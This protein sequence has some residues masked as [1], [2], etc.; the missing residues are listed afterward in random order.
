MSILTTLAQVQNEM[1]RGVFDFTK[2]GNCIGCG[3]CCSNYL[4]ISS[5]EI[6]DIKRYIQKYHIEEHVRV[7]PTTN[8]T[9]DMTCPFL[10]E[11]KENNKCT[12][13]PVRPQICRV[14]IRN[15]PPSKVKMNKEHFNR[16]RTIVDMRK[17]FFGG[18]GV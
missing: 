17:T 16:S 1:E 12:I 15:Q 18:G 13:Y 5:G 8:P 14:F 9:L 10:N 7:A 2:G 6:K 4:P 3:K 11:T